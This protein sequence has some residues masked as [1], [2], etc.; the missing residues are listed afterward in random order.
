MADLIEPC[1]ICENFIK[2]VKCSL[3]MCPVGLM[4]AENMAM[5]K[6]VIN[7]K[8]KIAELENAMSYM[9]SPNTIGDCHEMGCW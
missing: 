8:K 1:E 6:E 7:L 5:K 3:D 4:K 2:G 9:T